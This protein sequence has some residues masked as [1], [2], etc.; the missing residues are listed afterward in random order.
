[1]IGKDADLDFQFS[2]DMITAL[3]EALR[4]HRGSFV[5]FG[6]KSFIETNVLDDVFRQVFKFF[7]V[8]PYGAV[9]I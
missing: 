9:G 7:F 6:Y 5:H 1:M 2:T 8:L 4:I 3:D